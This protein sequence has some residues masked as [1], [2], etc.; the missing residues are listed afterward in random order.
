VS[1]D[2]VVDGAIARQN[3]EIAGLKQRLKEYEVGYWGTACKQ[4]D[5][6]IQKLREEN[7]RLKKRL[8]IAAWEVQGYKK[9]GQAAC[10]ELE[11]LREENARIRREN[12]SVRDIFPAISE[13]LDTFLLRLKASQPVILTPPWTP[14]KMPNAEMG[15]LVLIKNRRYGWSLFSDG[16]F[17]PTAKSL[18]MVESILILPADLLG[19]R[20]VG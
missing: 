17:E 8:G 6:E 13:P 9:S 1:E 20:R 15:S 10:K 12:Q 7:A 18:E 3:A 19:G 16:I 14:E 5:A 11:Q 4:R 2:E